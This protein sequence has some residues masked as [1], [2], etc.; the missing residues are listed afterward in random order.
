MDAT[1]E[2]NNFDIAND[3]PLPNT[4]FDGKV[5]QM[6]NF[7][8]KELTLEGVRDFCRATY[9]RPK[10]VSLDEDNTASIYRDLTGWTIHRKRAWTALLS[11][12]HYDYIDFSITVGSE[13]GTE[14]SRAAIRSWM[15]HLSEFMDSFDYVHSKLAPEWIVAAPQPLLA[16]SLSVEGRDFVAYLAD[17]REVTDPTAGESIGGEVTLMLPAGIYDLTLY[18]P[19]TGEYSPAIEVHGGEKSVVA[20]PSFKQDIV[21]R[22]TRRNQ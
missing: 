3:H 21:L 19:V 15:Q 2:S 17:Q 14:A 16:S 12:C 18:S 6:G 9:A 22:A 20:L 4:Q 11:G 7:M 10:P 1:F 5:F 8:S 13:S